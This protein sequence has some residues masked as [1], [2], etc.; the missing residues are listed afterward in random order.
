MWSA[1]L[2][3]GDLDFDCQAADCGGDL[4]G[5]SVSLKLP[6]GGQSADLYDEAFARDF[7]DGLV[8]EL[9]SE[10]HDPELIEPPVRYMVGANLAVFASLAHTV[11]GLRTRLDLYEIPA[12]FGMVLAMCFNSDTAYASGK[13]AALKLVEGIIIPN[14]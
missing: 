12:P 5:C 9:G 14:R 2:N 7:V 8:A 10:G 1:V 3:D 11:Q 4:A 13:S 6:D